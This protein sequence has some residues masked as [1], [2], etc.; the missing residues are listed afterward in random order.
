MRVHHRS[1]CGAQYYDEMQRWQTERTFIEYWRVCQYKRAT[2]SV[3]LLCALVLSLGKRT[4][5]H[6]SFLDVPRRRF[7]TR[8]HQRCVVIALP[9]CCGGCS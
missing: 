6:A 1:H 5:E 4:G 2:L 3:E 8:V 9:L 7:R